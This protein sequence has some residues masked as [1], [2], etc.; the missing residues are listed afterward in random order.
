MAE[1]AVNYYVYVATNRFHSR[2]YTSTTRDLRRR[3]NDHR[4]VSEQS[5]GGPEGCRKLVYYHGTQ[6]MHQALFMERKLRT[7][8]RQ[9][10]IRIINEE[11]PDWRDLSSEVPVR[12]RE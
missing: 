7:T 9:A 3:M 5:F 8:P 10:L 1:D 6:Y 2:L 4:R 12:Q 11:N